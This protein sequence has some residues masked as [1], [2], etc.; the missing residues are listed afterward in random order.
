MIQKRITTFLLGILL[1]VAIGTFGYFLIFH[2]QERWIDCLYM[3]VISITSV[4]YGEILDVSSSIAAQIFTMGLITF[5]MGFILYAISSITAFLIEGELS[6]VRRRR[7]MNREI[8]R[9]TGH[10]ILVGG[11]ET[12]RPLAHEL[13]T[14]GEQVVVIEQEG[15]A[16]APDSSAHPFL[17]IEG[18]PTDDVNLEKAGIGRAKG[19]VIALPQDKDSLYVTMT[20]RMMNKNLRIVAQVSDPKIA[21]KF[22]MAG[23]DSIVS[24]NTIGALRMAS[25][26]VRPAAVDFLDQMLRSEQGPLR[27][28][29]LPITPDSPM[30]GRRLSETDL[31]REHDLLVLG[32]K[33]KEA[34]LFNPD[35]DTLLTSG[36]TLVV[37]GNIDE[38]KRLQARVS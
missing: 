24:P 6:G 34:I 31:R 1:V 25:E 10:I 12:R 26:M 37:M 15:E 38:I 8:N 23:A 36:M 13:I 14:C 2:G 17:Y 35:A 11:G 9:L 20:A 18:D 33:D 5:G 32:L 27:I 3:T 7:R 21:P 4:G 22:T 29:E 16:P 28:H 19:V 30:D